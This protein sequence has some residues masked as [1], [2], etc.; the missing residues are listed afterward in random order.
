MAPAM[1]ARHAAYTEARER[2]DALAYKP[3]PL[4]KPGPEPA[5]LQHYYVR[6]S[7]SPTSER[8]CGI[9]IEGTFTVS[10]GTVRVY[11]MGGKLLGSSP[12]K[13]GDDVEVI[14]RKL[15]REHS[16]GS[17]FYGPLNY[18]RSSFH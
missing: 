11:D 17:G 8:D 3:P 16:G 10:D 2:A 5:G 15:L 14:A 13:P 9:I 4:P 1:A 18:P 7:I 6:V 12:Y